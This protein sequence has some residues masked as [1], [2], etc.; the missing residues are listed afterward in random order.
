MK[1]S[2][3]RSSS[4]KHS[5]GNNDGKTLGTKNLGRARRRPR[6]STG[7]KAAITHFTGRSF[8]LKRERDAQEEK[9]TKHKRPQAA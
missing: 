6:T 9:A 5:T 1:T 4:A 8:D 3:R 7:E 2:T